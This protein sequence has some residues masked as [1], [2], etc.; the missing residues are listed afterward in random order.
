MFLVVVLVVATLLAGAATAVVL[1]SAGSAAGGGAAAQVGGTCDFAGLYNQTIESVVL[2]RHRGGQGSGFVYRTLGGNDTVYVVTNQHVVGDASTVEV[3]FRGGTYETGTV[4]G[5]DAYADLAVVRV[6]D[7]PTES[8]ALDV[9]D[10]VP[11]PGTG[12]A[13]LGSPFG[14]QGSIT[15]GIVSGVNR[16]M[17]TE[18]GFSVPDVLQTDAPINPGN[19]GGPLVACDGTVVGVN[20]AGIQA[21]V[22]ENIG[23]AV[24]AP[25][26]QRVVPALIAD[27]DVE[28]PYLGVRTADV[29]PAVAEAN[30]LE[31][32]RGV[33]VVET[34]EGG[35]AAGVLRPSREVRTA[36]GQSVPVGGDV[37]VGIDGRTV[38]TGEDL[39]SYLATAAAPG[40]RVELTVLRDGQRRQVSVVL[41]ER[42]RQPTTRGGE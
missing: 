32:A 8:T 28:W 4:V 36:G 14:L 20:T 37:I 7:A 16:S 31:E 2:V 22:G 11:R 9:A 10:S 1:P 40:D 12:V 21:D 24:S 5:R 42:P 33:I 27:G 6:P 18:R 25:L 26:I 35:P 19:S 13:A 39:S 3:R 29:T 17:P 34:V 15:H 30:D 41:G 38:Q 23:F